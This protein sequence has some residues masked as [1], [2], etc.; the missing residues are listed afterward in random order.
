MN[1]VQTYYPP[2]RAKHG[3]KQVWISPSTNHVIKH[4]KEI[5]NWEADTLRIFNREITIDLSKLKQDKEQIIQH[6]IERK[7]PKYQCRHDIARIDQRRNFLCMLQSRAL[8][9]IDKQKKIEREEDRKRYV[10]CLLE[11]CE[12]LLPPEKH[13]AIRKLALAKYDERNPS[14]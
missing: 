7:A 6:N 10:V 14:S 13:E 11:A 1:Q 3:P 4:A 8:R 9:I 12:E 5:E 2:V